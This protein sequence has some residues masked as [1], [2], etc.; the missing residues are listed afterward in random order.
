MSLVGKGLTWT[1]YVYVH[2]YM[3]YPPSY[4]VQ[5]CDFKI[6]DI[7]EGTQHHGRLIENHFTSTLVFVSD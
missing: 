6:I 4:D 1:F 3:S 2:V 7:Q 5:R